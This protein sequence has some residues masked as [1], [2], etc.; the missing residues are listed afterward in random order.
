MQPNDQRSHPN[1]Q[2]SAP[3][4]MD[5]ATFRALGH[6]L[7]DQLAGLLASVPERPVTR[8]ESPSAIR[9]ALNLNGA[10]PEHGTAAGPLL[11]TTARLLF[12]HSLLN[13]HPK[14]F[15]YIT[16]APE[17]GRASCR[18]RVELSAVGVG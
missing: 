13:A 10:L 9:D 12:D 11:E 17:I 8:D 14:F 16:A 1:D 3:L 15:G 18:E 5:A 7:V 2:R 4:S 6:A